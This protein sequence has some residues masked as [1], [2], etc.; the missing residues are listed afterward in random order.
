MG[1]TMK[2]NYKNMTLS[3]V[4]GA[5]VGSFVA[6]VVMGVGYAIGAYI[7]LVPLGVWEQLVLKAYNVICQNFHM[8]VIC[9]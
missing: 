2:L 3:Q 1:D 7:V 8:V 9:V 4:V 6:R 5:L